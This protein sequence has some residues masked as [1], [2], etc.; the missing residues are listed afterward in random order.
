[1]ARNFGSGGE[2]IEI[3]A[4]AIFDSTF[5]SVAFRWRAAVTGGWEVAGRHQAATS[6]NGWGFSITGS[7]NRMQFYAKT[8]SGPSS[9]FGVVDASVNATDGNWHSA[10]GRYNRGSGGTGDLMVDGTST[11]QAT[12]VAAWNPTGQVIRID[13][14]RAERTK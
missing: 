10:V 7:P 13:V 6:F 5:G 12:G 8:S 14:R 4:N 11:A 2:Y 9:A 1:M 3:A